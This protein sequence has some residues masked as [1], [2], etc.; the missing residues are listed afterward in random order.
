M[1]QK[2]PIIV[3]LTSESHQNAQTVT[4][5]SKH[6]A[7]SVSG[8]ATIEY[9]RKQHGL[10][11]TPWSLT[12]LPPKTSLTIDHHCFEPI[13]RMANRS[14]YL[15]G[16]VDFCNTCVTVNIEMTKNTNDLCT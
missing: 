11:I 16:F 1:D 12:K 2:S 6:N 4:L 14:Q 13:A 8:C 3:F 9:S 15:F 7:I 5:L 10:T